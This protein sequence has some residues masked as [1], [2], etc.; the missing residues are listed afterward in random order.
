MRARQT[1]R[2]LSRL[3]DETLRPTGLQISQLT[4]LVA[5]ARFG[6]GGARIG[7]LAD[8]LAMERTTLTRSLGPLERSGL[9]RIARA[10]LDA[11]ARIVLLT[12][13]GERALEAAFP[14]WEKAQKRLG[15]LLGRRGAG[16]LRASAGRVRAV[17]SVGP[18]E[19]P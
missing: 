19:E 4:V 2:L 14:L 3:Y 8:A 12:A 16:E 5:V 18:A 6:E 7:A 13:A 11:R 10:P 17:L 9:V 15:A 1:S